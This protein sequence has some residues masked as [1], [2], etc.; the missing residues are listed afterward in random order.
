MQSSTDIAI[1]AATAAVGELSFQ[2][3]MVDEE[4]KFTTELTAAFEKR[5]QLADQGFN[6]NVVA[7]FGSQSTGKSTLLNRLFETRFDVMN[8]SMRQQTTK[9]IWMCK[10]RGANTLVMDVEG[11]DGRERGEDQ[12]FERKSALFSLSVAEVLIVN[13]WEQSV[14]LYNGANMGLLKTVF[15]VNLQLF[16]KQGSPK[17]CIFF[18][19]RDFTNRTPLSKL[20]DTLIND[21]KRIWE[22]LVKPAGKESS[23]ITDFFDFEY[24]GLPHKIYA[25]DRFEEAV[26]EMR[27]RFYNT[28][29]AGYVFKPNYHKRIP[30]DGFQHFADS[31]WEKIVSNRD[32]DLPTQQ[33]LLAQYRCDEIA[34]TVYDRV[35]AEFKPLRHKI[36]SGH[37]VEDLGTIIRGLT[38][39]A[40]AD[41]D[42]DASR[43]NAQVYQA[44]REEFANQMYTA[45]S[46]LFVQQLR[47]LH[48]LSITLFN[49]S[50]AAKIKNSEADFALKL[51]AAY[52][53]AE[54]RFR[55]GAQAA[56]IEEAG[57]TYEEQHTLFIAELDDECAKKRTEA[58]QRMSKKLESDMTTQLQHPVKDLFSRPSRLLWADVLR[59][60]NKVVETVT[61]TL[62]TS[63]NGFEVSADLVAEEIKQTKVRAWDLL[64]DTIK[65]EVSEKQLLEKL[66]TK[67]ESRFRYDDKGIP[68]FWSPMDD[69]DG[70]FAAARGLADEL[71][72][73]LA[74]FKVP[75]SEID[76]DVAE[77]K[78]I[79]EMPIVLIS[80]SRQEDAR[81]A[82]N[83]E[84]HG[85]FVEAKR[86][87]VATT[88][89]I[90]SWFIVMTVVLGWNEFMA[91][92]RNPVLTMG[93]IVSLVAAYVV[94]RT[95]MGGPLLQVARVTTG[96]IGRQVKDNLRGRGLSMDN[97]MSHPA[98]ER[99]RRGVSN[100]VMFGSNTSVHAAGEADG[101]DYEL[102]H[103]PKRAATVASSSRV[104]AEVHGKANGTQDE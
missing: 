33:Q 64:M 46:V 84:A 45:L 59:T 15:E 44:K 56:I 28:S 90:P 94:Y 2:V 88:A 75:L 87:T 11:T 35:S 60:Y 58:M 22:G 18:V 27:E 8:E 53:E 52:V 62:E 61:G 48:K 16:Q 55:D 25:T 50:L 12:D 17:T 80:V 85:Q 102:T 42:K 98:V 37:V 21:L 104:H 101:G 24:V 86:S 5:W 77:R 39:T 20:A 36:D 69:I 95:N 91:I 43:Y 30:I 40:L 26:D 4:Q 67:F 76:K 47:N 51:K 14:G 9:G 72:S 38:K 73:Q 82:F 100:S 34:K 41:F 19:L 23:Q 99:V 29:S 13:M 81:A 7:V 31:V 71:L 74:E 93:L 79:K 68:R 83:R 103:R 57:W 70:V 1:A 96:E 65:E 54:T 63:L 78:G 32:L 97:I 10:A 66:R 92:L 49:T 3:Q 89:K 6:Y